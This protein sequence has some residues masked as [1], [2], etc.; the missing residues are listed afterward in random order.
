VIFD[1]FCGI[2]S[3]VR[4]MKKKKSYTLTLFIA[5][6]ASLTVGQLTINALYNPRYRVP[7]PEPYA[8]PIFMRGFLVFPKITPATTPY[9]K[10]GYLVKYLPPFDFLARK[11]FYP[12]GTYFY[13]D[14]GKTVTVGNNGFCM[15]EIATGSE[16]NCGFN[17][18]PVFDR[19]N[20]VSRA[21]QKFCWHHRINLAR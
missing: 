2:L 11:T 5:A 18:T 16:D 19:Q 3:K 20:P 14:A 13:V 12:H 17:N 8:P 6:I 21:V 15:S 10:P 7:A 4:A 1:D 9:G